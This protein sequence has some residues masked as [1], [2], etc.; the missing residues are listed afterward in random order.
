MAKDIRIKKDGVWKT[1]NNVKK[2]KTKSEKSGTVTWVPEDEYP[3]GD[4]EVGSNGVWTAKKDGL[5][6]Y[7]KFTVSNVT[8]TYLTGVGVDGRHRSYDVNELGMI[9]SLILPDSI[10][11]VFD[12][13]FKTGYKDGEV[14]DLTG[15]TIIA[16]SKGDKWQD[17][18]DSE[19]IPSQYKG[20]IVPLDEIDVEPL[21][22]KKIITGL[23][24][25][26]FGRVYITWERPIDYKELT[27]DFQIMIFG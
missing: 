25:L 9:K 2:I 20:S 11:L 3:R 13:N 21:V 12:S 4:K 5:Y 27:A 23:P 1:F 6:G 18:E 15:L 19:L 8:K 26:P 10:Q 17:V 16:K 24:E 7:R 22:A 14:I